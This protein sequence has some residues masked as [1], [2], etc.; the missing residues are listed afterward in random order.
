M[1]S[2]KAQALWN[3]LLATAKAGHAASL[4]ILLERGAPTSLAKDEEGATALIHVARCQ[5]GPW[6]VPRG[7]HEGRPEGKARP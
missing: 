6:G 3:D 4:C 5:W 1:M 7:P 2:C